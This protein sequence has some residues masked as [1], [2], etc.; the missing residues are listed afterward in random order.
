MMGTMDASTTTATEYVA[1][2]SPLGR[3]T[4]AGHHGVVTH[5]RMTDQAHPP[6]DEADWTPAAEGAFDHVVDQLER[7][8]DGDLTTFDVA[9]ELHGTDFQKRVWS[10]LTEIPYGATWSYGELARHIGSP[11]SS[12]AVGLANGRNPVAIIVP[13][14]RVIGADGSMTGYGGGIERKVRLLELE[15]SRRAPQLPL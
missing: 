11:G 2:D 12:R 6:S 14:H 3:L 10:A 5:L 13:C 4:I 15:R 7:Y 8:F 9:V 1:V